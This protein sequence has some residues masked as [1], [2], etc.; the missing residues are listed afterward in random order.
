M[1]SVSNT[2][3]LIVLTINLNIIINITNI[4]KGVTREVR[5]KMF[6][7][8]SFL[9]KPQAEKLHIIVRIKRIGR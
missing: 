3:A 9:T 8:V 2:H 5:F 1:I 4:L 7:F 6:Y